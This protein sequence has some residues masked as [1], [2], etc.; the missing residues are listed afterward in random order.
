MSMNTY[1]LNGIPT[2]TNNDDAVNKV[3]VDNRISNL[4]GTYAKLTQ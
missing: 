4:S 2:P 3:Y 1:K